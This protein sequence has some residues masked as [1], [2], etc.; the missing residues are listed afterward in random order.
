V[1]EVSGE[2]EVAAVRGRRVDASALPNE[3]ARFRASGGALFVRVVWGVPGLDVLGPPGAVDDALRGLDLPRATLEELDA[4]RILA[5][6]P[7]FGRDFNASTLV[8]ETPLLARGVSMTKGCYP[9]QES[10]ARVHN[11]GRVRFLLR[12]LQADAALN[13]GRGLSLKGAVVGVVTSAA[14]APAGDFVA[15]ARVRSE[16]EAGEVVDSAGTRASIVALP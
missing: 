1:A 3:E 16:I 8:N 14:R 13:E 9:G 6:R 2:I 10:V 12:G 5:G 15:I 4:L 7:V 11:L